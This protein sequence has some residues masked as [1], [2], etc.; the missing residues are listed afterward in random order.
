MA[1]NMGSLWVGAS[2]LQNSQNAMNITANNLTNVDTTGYVRQQVL[3]ADKTYISSGVQAA[4]SK[5]TNGLGV[6]VSDVIHNRD[7]FIDKSYRQETGRYEFYSASY[8]ASTEIEDILQELDG[9][10]FQDILSSDN[11]SL[12]VAFQE[13]VKDPSSSVNQTLVLQKASLFITRAQ[14][15][16]DDMSTYQKQLNTQISDMV[17]QINELG[18]TIY[19]L[20][21]RIQKIE[22]SGVETATTLRDER[23]VALDELAKLTNLSY[24][25]TP[26]GIVKV[27]IEGVDFVNESKVYEIGLDIDE[28][29]DFVTPIWPQLGKNAEGEN[30]EVYDLTAEISTAYNSDIGKLKGLLLARGEKAADYRDMYDLVNTTAQYFN[31]LTAADYKTESEYK[32][33]TGASVCLNSQAEFDTL[34][35]SIV[36]SINDI[37]S[38]LTTADQLGLGIGTTL[39]D[40]EGNTYTVT[41]NTR[42]LDS[43]SCCMGSDKK[44]PPQELFVRAGC[45]RYT[46]V[47]DASGATYYLYNEEDLTDTSKMYTITSLSINE[48]IQK[49]SS[50]IPYMEQNGEVSYK[51]GNA[52]SQVWNQASLQL[53]PS[54]GGSWTF[55]EY[56]EQMIGELGTN[57]NVFKTTVENL[58]STTQALLTSRNSIVGVSSDE[59]L[60]KMIKYQNAYNAASRYINV[61]SEMIEHLLTNL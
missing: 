53:N 58:D 46:E 5:Q 12:W 51:L 24:K 11:E 54:V 61:V 13:L 21:I 7:V 37:L 20:N 32:D 2:G 19:D 16:Y 56:Y 35:H 18:N 34:I 28:T 8:D 43:E 25:E 59:E 23:D 30:Y 29:S 31:E 55:A 38:P 47:T 15:V 41:E 1:N 60:T 42:L 10:S 50:K 52:L 39:T 4:I 57:G 27:S 9:E 45:S 22:A 14:A 26:E 49:D 3:F 6:S 33:V 48:E 36:T 44:L 17:G 40:A